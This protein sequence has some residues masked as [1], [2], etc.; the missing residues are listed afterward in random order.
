MSTGM[1][2]LLTFDEHSDMNESEE[3]S[4]RHGHATRVKINDDDKKCPGC[5]GYV[6]AKEKFVKESLNEGST[7]VIPTMDDLAKAVEE[8]GVNINI[9]YTDKSMTINGKTFRFPQMNDHW[10]NSDISKSIAFD[11]KVADYLHELCK[12]K[13]EDVHAKYEGILN[14]IKSLGELRISHSHFDYGPTAPASIRK[15]LPDVQEW[16]NK[17][18][19][20]ATGEDFNKTLREYEVLRHLFDRQYLRLVKHSLAKKQSPVTVTE[21]PD[22]E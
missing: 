2:R 4:T 16:V 17:W 12:D 10:Q 5:G 20:I 22:N 14:Q 13:W 19:E 18:R 3:C 1:T 11:D 15:V 9:K 7:F 6:N 21:E 8:I